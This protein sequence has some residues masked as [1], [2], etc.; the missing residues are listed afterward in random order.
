MR[1]E[2]GREGSLR[3][4]TR[5]IIIIKITGNTYG[6]VHTLGTRPRPRGARLNPTRPIF[7]FRPLLTYT[8]K[9][10]IAKGAT[11]H[12]PCHNEKDDAET[13]RAG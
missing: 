8:A 3:P 12:G 2:V 4:K 10:R 1:G 11:S 13:K 6:R 9:E 7:R 5:M